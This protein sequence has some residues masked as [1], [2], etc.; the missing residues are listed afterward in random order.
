MILCPVVTQWTTWYNN[1]PFFFSQTVSLRFLII[2]HFHA[3]YY[4]ILSSSLILFLQLQTVTYQLEIHIIRSHR[5]TIFY[6]AAIDHQC[7][8]NTC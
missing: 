7:C 4:G 6:E 3:Q 2:S 8:A 1:K 5:A